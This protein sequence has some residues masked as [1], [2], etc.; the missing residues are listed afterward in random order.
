MIPTATAS[1]RTI[2]R[3]VCPGASASL[4]AQSSRPEG[5]SRTANPWGAVFSTTPAS[6]L[7]SPTKSATNPVAGRSYTSAGGPT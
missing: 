4:R 6:T 5:D 7:D 2:G 3:T 1:G